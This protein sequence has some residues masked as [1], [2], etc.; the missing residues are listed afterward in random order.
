MKKLLLT[1]S[2]LIAIST[3]AQEDKTVTLTVI[4]QGKTKDDA[5]KNALRS[6][7]E[8]AFGT[9]ISSKTEILNDNLVKDEIV[10]VTNGNIRKFDIISEVQLPDNTWSSTLIAIVSVTKLTSFCESKGVVVEFKGQMFAMNIKLQ[11]LNEDAELK[12]INNLCEAG[13]KLLPFVFNDSLEIDNPIAYKFKSSHDNVTHKIN[14]DR[15]TDL[16]PNYYQEGDDNFV[17]KFR[18]K[19]TLNDYYNQLF[20]FFGKN[21][22]SICLSKEELESYKSLKKETYPIN[23]NSY[24]IHLRNQKSMK[25]LY[26]F[27][28]IAQGYISDFMIY[29]EVDTIKINK[30]GLLNFNLENYSTSTVNKSWR[31]PSYPLIKMTSKESYKGGSGAGLKN[32]Q[33]ALETYFFDIKNKQNWSQHSALNGDKPLDFVENMELNFYQAGSVIGYFSYNHILSLK[34]L[35]KIT[36]YKLI[37]KK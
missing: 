7:I 8:Q 29:S 11:K 27:F 9:F 16:Y 34:S 18:V 30:S 32:T 14:N 15:F 23:F 36:S 4:G 19:I 17:I 31:I 10:S 5:Q 24:D 22:S 25:T 3:F 20:E 2:M 13:N 12:A 37:Q 21:L 26:D 35:E 1:I 28:I 33:N 6:A